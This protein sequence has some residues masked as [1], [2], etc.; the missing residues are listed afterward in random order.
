MT[1]LYLVRHGETIWNAESRAQGSRNVALSETGRQQAHLLAERIQHYAI[2]KII[3]SDLDRAYETGKILGETLGLEVEKLEA[4]KEMNFGAWEGLTIS[5]IQAKYSA[6]YTIWRNK[7]HDAEIPDGE[8]LIRVQ[9]RGLD[10]INRIVEDNANKNIVV[11]SH[12]TMIKAIIL[13]ILDIDLS[14]FYKIK[15]DNTSM[16]IIEYKSYGPVV[17]TLNDI[18]HLD[19]MVRS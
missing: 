4:L 15:Q 2:D 9:K 8:S 18:A 11:V 19:K 17:V 10:S 3:S 14:Y 13:G 5:E 12:G 1:R 16:N 7:P 6:H